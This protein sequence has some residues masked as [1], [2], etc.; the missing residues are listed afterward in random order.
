MIPEA[1]PAPETLHSK[2]NFIE[3]LKITYPKLSVSEG[4]KK[5]IKRIVNKLEKSAAELRIEF[6]IC[7]IHSGH[8]RDQLDYLNLTPNE[9]NKY[10][11][12]YQLYFRTW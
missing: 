4:V 6:Q 1:K 5:E 2:L 12:I 7:E 11:N 10:L 3:D 9:Y 8:I